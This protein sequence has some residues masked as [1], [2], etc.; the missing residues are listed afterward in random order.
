ML[1]MKRIL[2]LLAVVLVVDVFGA[3]IVGGEFELLHLSGFQYRLNLIWYFDVASN[4]IPPRRLP[5][6]DEPSIEVAIF[7]K[8]DDMLVRRV[9]LPFLSR[10]PV[11]YTQPACS[12]GELQTAKL[13]YTTII[14]LS[15]EQFGDPGGYY[16][17]W[18]RCCRNYGILNIL[19]GDPNKG[20]IAAGQTFYYEFSPVVKN[21]EPFINSSPRNFPT[22]ADYACPGKPYYVDFAGI[23]DDGDSLVYSLVTPLST[24][25]SQASPGVFPQPY[26]PIQWQK[27]TGL[28]FGIDA[29]VNGLP[30]HA[31]YPDLWIS[32]EGF[33]RVTPRNLG[34]YVFAVKIEEYRD[35]VKIGETRRD[36]Q[37]LVVDCRRSVPPKIAG[38]RLT[39][40]PTSNQSGDLAVSFSNTVSDEDRCIIVRVTDLDANR[41]EDAFTEFIRI[42]AVGLNFKRK[43]LPEILPAESTGYIHNDEA[44]EFRICFPKCPYFEGGAYQIG[45]IAFDDAC[46]LPLSDTLK[47]A[48]TVQPPF[49]ER[50]RFVTGDVNAILNEGDKMTWPFEARDPEGEQLTLFAKAGGFILESAGITINQTSDGSGG[51]LTGTLEWDAACG[52]FDFFDRTNFQIQLMADDDDLCDFNEPDTASFDLTVLL[53]GN[54]DPIA[55]TDLTTEPQEHQVDVERRVLQSLTFNV[56]A[57]DLIDNDAV[58]IRLAGRN[59]KPSDYGMSF[60]KKSGTGLVSSTF[61]WDLLCDKVVA[62]LKEEYELLFI[63][64]D[65]T[66][67]CRLRKRDTVHV[68]VNVLPPLNNPPILNVASLNPNVTYTDGAVEAK[69]G[70][71]IRIS[72]TVVDEDIAP[73]EQVRIDLVKAEGGTHPPEGFTFTPVTGA[74]PQTATL[75]WSPD[76][77]IFTDE[78]YSNDYFFTF[79]YMDNHCQSEVAD[80]LKMSINVRD[81]LTQDFELDPPN[82][83]TPNG[84]NF[85]EYFAM[86][87]MQDDGPVNLLPPDNCVGQFR[88]VRIYNRWGRTV[89]EST[90]R[91][92]RWY[93]GDES[94]GVYYYFIEYTNREYKGTVSLRN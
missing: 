54:A 24:H 71:A 20:Q 36:F 51:V 55:D 26:P 23:D 5:E 11:A 33:F 41:E 92:F 47:V 88:N 76:C 21:G 31:E 74:S 40:P 78:T 84:D 62:D 2:T 85:N 29:V 13:I 22:L 66:N 38:R 4:P 58:T 39:D 48:V 37:L 70:E 87:R 80:T 34:L 3:H 12:E 50:A 15:P 86:E 46:A 16:I 43:D 60:L 64:I 69:V 25:N 77:T 17:S 45:I 52:K 82:V 8:S 65:S 91:N 73:P 94:A 81:V 59:F 49:N 75:E 27:T 56:T 19:S 32:H 1:R 79:I 83:F 53:P 67:K 61:T 57:K 90:D 42:R 9:G 35:K 72:L 89:F 93:G 6:V 68:F 14:V 30:R 28:E 7:R 18:E 63:A 10:T 44:I